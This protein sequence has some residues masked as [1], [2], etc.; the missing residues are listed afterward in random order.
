M[1]SPIGALMADSHAMLVGSIDRLI[2]A[3]VE[4][5]RGPAIGMFVI[6]GIVYATR[7]SYDN[8]QRAELAPYMIRATLLLLGACTLDLANQYVRAGLF[9]ALPTWISAGMAA[10][11][12]TAVSIAGAQSAAAAFNVVHAQMWVVIAHAQAQAGPLDLSLHTACEIAGFVGGLCLGIMGFTYT[13]AEWTIALLVVAFP[14]VCLASMLPVFR[15]LLAR[16][17]GKL[18]SVG[19]LLFF[20]IATLQMVL[21]MQQGYLDR[22]IA[23]NEAA[24]AAT[25]GMPWWDLRGRSEV[26]A[27]AQASSVQALTSMVIMFVFGLVVMYALP[28]L[29]YSL[30]TGIAMPQGLAVAGA[31]V[32]LQRAM[33]ALTQLIRSESR[34]PTPGLPS[35]PGRSN[36][37]VSLAPKGIGYAPP[38]VG[39]PSAGRALPPP[40]VAPINR[41]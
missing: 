25:A 20:G 39:A 22:I 4:M 17:A 9:E 2:E 5:A 29:A 38:L 18:L 8:R 28:A 14:Q 11:G 1:I 23:A 19:F 33:G 24:D 27:A 6:G 31:L 40:P 16:W 12:A 34:I 41:S 36:L 30:G 35:L 3:S 26:T 37:N 32:G 13:L 10:V 21:T 15:D 7:L